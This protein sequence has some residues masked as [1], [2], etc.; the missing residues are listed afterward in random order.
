MFIIQ[1]GSSNMDLNCQ[2]NHASMRI[3]AVAKFQVSRVRL[4]FWIGCKRKMWLK[5]S[6]P[7]QL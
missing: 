1:W 2:F 6:Y 4:T 5:Y 7:I 3:G